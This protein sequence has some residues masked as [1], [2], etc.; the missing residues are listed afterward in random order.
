MTSKS[1]KSQDIVGVK[2]VESSQY[3]KYDHL[4]LSITRETRIINV[5]NT[6]A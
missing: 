5:C 3:R 1:R 4:H 2:E 6:D